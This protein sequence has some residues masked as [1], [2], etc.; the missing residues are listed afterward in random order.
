MSFGLKNAGQTFQRLMDKVGAGLDFVFIYLDDILV[1]SKDEREHK[2]HLHLIL[3]RLREYGLV[4]NL[5][6]CELGRNSVEFLGHKISLTGVQPVLKH[7]AVIQQYGRPVD[8][9]TLQSF[10][11]LVNFYRC[12]IPGAAG[13]L[14]PLRRP[15]GCG[16]LPWRLL[17]SQ[18]NGQS[19]TPRA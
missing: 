10:L 16:L 6:K 14:K 11:G 17:S 7:L 3:E 19:A 12:F 15:S 13:L 8:R 9:K 1:A 5:E 18:P 2:V 4:L